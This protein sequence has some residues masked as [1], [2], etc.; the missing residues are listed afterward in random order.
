MLSS[1]SHN[2]DRA[3]AEV[4]TRSGGDSRHVVI[5]GPMGVGKTTVGRMLADRMGLPFVD[6]DEIIEKRTGE[7]GAEIASRDGIARLHA[8]ELEV[9]LDSVR[10]DSRS[11]IAPASSVVDDEAG[12]RAMAGCCTI[13]LAAPDDVLVA[14]QASGDHRRALDTT[15]RA[16]LG[17]RR[18]PHREA[19][20]DLR[21]DTGSLRPDDVIDEIVTAGQEVKDS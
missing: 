3:E 17:A 6:S 9:F 19:L 1:T 20:S 4:S 8:L 12:R 5:T 2:P 16:A 15:E 10:S 18:E 13:W 11:V 21:V 14:R 7:S